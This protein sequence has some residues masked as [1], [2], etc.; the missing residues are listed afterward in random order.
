MVYHQWLCF[1]SNVRYH[2]YKRESDEIPT[3][4]SHCDHQEKDQITVNK[5]HSLPASSSPQELLSA[6]DLDNST[7]HREVMDSSGPIRIMDLLIDN[8]S[9]LEVTEHRMEE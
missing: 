9:C 2:A 7:D 6:T 1:S 4:F 3:A 5:S 8:S